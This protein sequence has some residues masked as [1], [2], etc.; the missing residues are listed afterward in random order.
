M[1]SD[2]KIQEETLKKFE[3]QRSCWVKT[4][5]IFLVFLLITI[6]EWNNIVALGNNLWL[7]LAAALAIIGGIWWF[8]TMSIIKTLIS[9]RMIEIQ[10]L[11][12]TIDEIKTV[13][14][15]IKKLK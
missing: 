2:W 6:L 8:W 14:Q 15:E 13:H 4:G 7:A 10:I 11:S 5:A 12:H 9:Y 1:N 3:T